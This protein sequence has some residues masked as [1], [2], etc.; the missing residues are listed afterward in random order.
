MMSSLGHSEAEHVSFNG[1]RGFCHLC[2]IEL[3]SLQHQ[4]QHVDE[5][6][7]ENKSLS[8]SM[9]GHLRNNIE[10]TSDSNQDIARCTVLHCVIERV[11]MNIFTVNVT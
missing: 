11:S 3:I 6:Q 9:P 4:K 5:K 8:V 10:H 2:N 1:T 7:R